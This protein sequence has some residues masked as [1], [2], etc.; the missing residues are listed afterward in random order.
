MGAPCES[1]SRALDRAQQG[2]HP[3]VRAP[4]ALPPRP[5]PTIETCGRGWI[6]KFVIAALVRLAGCFCPAG[7]WPSERPNDDPTW[8]HLEL[9]FVGEPSLRS[10]EHTSELQSLAY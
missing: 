10:E 8:L 3:R 5:L 1:H 9:H 2:T 4:L 6:E 7:S